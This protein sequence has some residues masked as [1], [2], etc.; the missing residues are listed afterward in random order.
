MPC[1]SMLASAGLGQTR[2]TDHR[3]LRREGLGAAGLSSSRAVFPSYARRRDDA[4]VAGSPK[5]LRKGPDPPAR[6]GPKGGRVTQSVLADG[7][8]ALA[9][10]RWA[11]GR[12]S[13]RPVPEPGLDCRGALPL[14]GVV[15]LRPGAASL[16]TAGEAGTPA[17]THVAAEVHRHPSH[18]GPLHPHPRE[19]HSVSKRGVS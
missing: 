16:R 10:C 6:F 12:G 18:R 5:G 11:G 7:S 13:P 1:P 9:D 8:L 19:K 2:H 4:K 17:P 15:R 3:A 14:S